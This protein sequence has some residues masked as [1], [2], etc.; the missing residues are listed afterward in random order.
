MFSKL[1]ITVE[2]SLWWLNEMNFN[3]TKLILVK[4]EQTFFAEGEENEILDIYH[5]PIISIILGI[6]RGIVYWFTDKPS[7][8][9]PKSLLPS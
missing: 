5:S 2:S 7:Q 3:D 1:A 6:P 4:I 8:S 9:L